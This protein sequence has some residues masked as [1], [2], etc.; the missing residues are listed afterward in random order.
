MEA[1][2]IKKADS[3]NRSAEVRKE[4]AAVRTEDTD[5]SFSA[6]QEGQT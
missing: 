3:Q 4:E 6:P 5:E 1:G 2:Q